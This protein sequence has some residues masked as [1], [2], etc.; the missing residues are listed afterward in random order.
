MRFGGFSSVV[1]LSYNRTDGHRGNMGFGQYGGYAKLGYDFSDN[2]RVRG[3]SVSLISM[4]Q[5]QVRSQNLWKT[6]IR[7]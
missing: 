1:S 3:M 5:I 4:L 6:R 7:T 2:W